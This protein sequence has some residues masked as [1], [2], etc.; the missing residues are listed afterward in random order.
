MHVRFKRQHPATL[1]R[2]WKMIR[3]R[4]V[5]FILYSKKA[6]SWTRRMWNLRVQLPRRHQSLIIIPLENIQDHQ[7]E[8]WFSPMHLAVLHRMN[9]NDVRCVSWIL[10]SITDP[11]ALDAAVQLAGEI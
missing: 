5:S 8:L 4:I 2:L 6:L 10:R 7:S 9:T 3:C 1:R 11:E